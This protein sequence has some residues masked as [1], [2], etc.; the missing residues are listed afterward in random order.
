MQQFVCTRLKNTGLVGPHLSKINSYLN[1]QVLLIG[2]NYHTLFHFAKHINCCTWRAKIYHTLRKHSNTNG[3]NRHYYK[4]FGNHYLPGRGYYS[5]QRLT[6]SYIRWVCTARDYGSL[7]TKVV[8]GV[9]RSNL[10]VYLTFAEMYLQVLM[11][12]EQEGNCLH[13]ERQEAM[14]S[15]SRPER[16]RLVTDSLH[17]TEERR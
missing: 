5:T 9:W 3:I 6:H 10:A 17:H 7:E 14:D 13:M 2:H 1:E 4:A 11:A 15:V 8:A 16:Q 12:I